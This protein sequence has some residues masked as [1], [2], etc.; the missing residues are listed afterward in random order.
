MRSLT[1]I[2]LLLMLIPGLL[3][4]QTLQADLESSSMQIKGT[5]SLHDWESE[6]QSFDIS[7]MQEGNLIRDLEGN[8]E[9][10]SI[11]SGKSIMD[12]KTYNALGADKFPD[13][14]FQAKQLEIN[15]GIISGTISVTIKDQ[16]KEFEISTASTLSSGN[17][18]VS[19]EVPL[20]MMEFGIDPPTA[21]FG[22]LTTGKDV[23]IAFQITLK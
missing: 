3:I 13:I 2:T 7:G 21:M 23:K 16:T 6:V 19:G 14:K 5:S 8:L 17:I 22:T 9:V 20:D 18:N 10:K 1:S 15:N 12:D 11:K 4:G